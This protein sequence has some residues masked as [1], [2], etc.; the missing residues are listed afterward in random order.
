MTQGGPARLSALQACAHHGMIMRVEAASAAAAAGNLSA[1]CWPVVP[2]QNNLLEM[3]A[4]FNFCAPDVLG[5]AADFKCEW[6]AGGSDSRSAA[7]SRLGAPRLS[8]MCVSCQFGAGQQVR[9]V[10]CDASLLVPR[11]MQIC[12]SLL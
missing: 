1:A 10:F 11:R 7:E 6:E 3:W 2:P 8:A 12:H 9:S 4:L 5:S